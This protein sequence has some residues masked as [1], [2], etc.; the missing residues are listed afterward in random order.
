MTDAGV[1]QLL[2]H[3]GVAWTGD[4][5]EARQQALLCSIADDDLAWP[6]LH[7]PPRDPACSRAAVTGHA[8]IGAV[9][10]QRVERAPAGPS[11]QQP[12]EH[13]IEAVRGRDVDARSE[14][15]TSELQSLM[16]ISYADFCLNKKN[17]QLK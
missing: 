6:G 7:A 13:G 1:V 15:H 16:R 12:V 2:G 10:Q 11:T 8:R 17:N 3:N 14:E 9:V 5:R 4:G